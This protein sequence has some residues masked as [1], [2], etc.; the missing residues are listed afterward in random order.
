MLL[1]QNLL[2]IVA[3]TVGSPNVCLHHTKAHIK[4]EKIG[5]TFPT[6]QVHTFASIQFAPH[7][8]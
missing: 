5:A 7:V 8:K 1:N 2:D 4:P 3:E 6:H